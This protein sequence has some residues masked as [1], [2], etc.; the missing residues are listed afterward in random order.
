MTQNQQLGIV[1]YWEKKLLHRLI[2]QFNT[3]LLTF[4]PVLLTHLT[5]SDQRNGYTGCCT[6]FLGDQMLH[7]AD[8]EKVLLLEDRFPSNFGEVT[9]NQLMVALRIGHK[10]VPAGPDP[11]PNLVKQRDP[12]SVAPKHVQN[13][14]HDHYV[15]FSIH[16]NLFNVR[17]LPT[18]VEFF[19]LRPR[20]ELGDT[21]GSQVHGVY[22]VSASRCHEGVP[23]LPAP[24]IKHR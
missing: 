5:A 19:H 17:H 22:A 1:L 6:G 10:R 7:A 11:S 12:P 21:G 8:K 16:F 3:L 18:D 24:Q 15:I 4:Y 13:A 20:N 2:V 23:T 14:I 9:P